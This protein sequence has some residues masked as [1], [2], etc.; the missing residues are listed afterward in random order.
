MSGRSDMSAA[1]DLD[2]K[3]ALVTG[4]GKVVGAAI[5]RELARHGALVVVNA[6]HS[7]QAAEET[8]ASIRSAGGRAEMLR[9]SSPRCAYPHPPPRASTGPS[10]WLCRPLPPS[11]PR[12][13]AL[14]GGAGG[15]L[16]GLRRP[17]RCSRGVARHDGPLPRRFAGRGGGAPAA[18]RTRP[19]RAA[20]RH[21]GVPRRGARTDRPRGG[22]SG[23]AD[24]ER[25]PRPG[26]RP[27]R[28][29]RSYDDPRLRAHLGRSALGAAAAHLRRGELE[30]ALV[31]G[32]N[33]V[34]GPLLTRLYGIDG[35]RKP[36]EG[37]FTLVLT[38]AS[39]SRARGW[40]LLAA[41]DTLLNRLPTGRHEPD[42]WSYLGADDLVAALRHLV[43][44]DPVPASAA[45]TSAVSTRPDESAPAHATRRHTL[46]WEAAGRCGTGARPLPARTLVITGPRCARALCA[47]V[48]AG[49]HC[50]LLAV[51]GDKDPQQAVGR[52]LRDTPEGFRHLRVVADLHSAPA[53]P[54]PP[55]A[56]VLAL[57]EAAFWAV[58]QSRD[59][60]AA[61]GT[62]AV[63]VTAP[64]VG[65]E[66][67]PH[68]HLFTGFVKSLAW[69]LTGCT[70]RAVVGDSSE[71]P[72][73]LAALED[74]LARP[75]DGL[76]VVRHRG[77]TRFVQRLTEN[78]PPVTGEDLPLAPRAVVVATGGARGI[79]A[80]C[81]LALARDVPLRLRLVGSS[82][83][84]E[85][86]HDLLHTPDREL[87]A[88]RARYITDQ[89][90]RTP[91]RPVGEISAAFDRLL[92]ARESALTLRAL[93][94]SC[95]AGQVHFHTCDVTDANAVRAL[96][97]AVR[98]QE[99]HVDLLVNGA[100]LH[101]PG[102]IT[103]KTLPGMRRIRD[104]KL[105]GYHHLRA[106][107]T[108]AL[109]PRLWCNFG[110][111]TGVAAAHC[112]PVT[113]AALLAAPRDGVRIGIDIEHLASPPPPHLLRYALRPREGAALAERPATVQKE[114]FLTLW[115]AKEA[116]AK[117]LGWSLLRAL[118]DV[119]I[120]LCPRLS[121]ARLGQD[122]APLGWHLLPLSLPGT[123]HTVTLVTHHRSHRPRRESTWTSPA[124][125]H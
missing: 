45:P 60:I 75:A 92:H 63:G 123:P 25:D 53:W 15:D 30:L 21:L 66:A 125:P 124:R 114:E 27:A 73:V 104:V 115:T 74:E 56:D 61:G 65:A 58:R 106:A 52:V 23:R 71:P 49:V 99:G 48:E 105:S 89:R 54:A 80:A 101:H 2:G 17:H 118:V 32:V 13:P 117:A 86:P 5:S 93:S 24:A 107:F 29:A 1:R 76:P 35:S 26:R 95:G 90:T 12:T 16:R 9:A 79:T 18:P 68:A 109:T 28:P 57:Q 3:I 6:F 70:V 85:A 100:G 81:L 33:G 55:A 84:D 119:E 50:R 110:S 4:G 83:P 121:L 98:D 88:A 46:S 67:A 39:V 62:V 94:E 113:V 42:G 96:A 51:D 78:D 20:E 14:V 44:R 91:R 97:D 40:P 122:P 41:L 59:R 103:R 112:G 77:N 102:D 72:A 10:S 64:F 31:L 34:T 87:P 37:A 47:I 108:G 8:V 19:C 69:E 22:H 116:I 120:T 82:R 11:A 111:V 43:A 36:A 7:P 38:R